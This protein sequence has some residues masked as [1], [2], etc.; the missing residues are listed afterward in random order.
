MS[1]SKDSSINVDA[2][3][4]GPRSE[5][6]VFFKEMM[7]FAVGEHVHWRANYHPEDPALVTPQQQYQPDFRHT[8]YRTEDILRQLSARLKAQ[9]V[10]FFSPRYLGH[11]NA[12]TLMVSNLAYTMTAMYNPNNCA[13]EVSPVTTQLELEVGQQL[14]QMFGYSPE[15]AWGHLTSGGTVANY[16]GL[17]VARNLKTFPMAIA[18]HQATADLVADL[19]EQDLLN[20]A[21]DAVLDLISASQ[22][23]GEF[24]AVRDLSARGVGVMPGQLGKLLVP[25][26]KHYSWQKAMDILGLGQ[27]N[28]VPLPLDENYRTDI[29]AL[30]QIVDEMMQAGTPILGVIAVVGTTEEGSVDPVDAVVALRERCQQQYGRSFYIHV[31]AAYAGYARSLFVG[32][33][34][35]LLAYDDLIAH[36]RQQDTIPEGVQWP[37]PEVYSAFAALSKVDSITVDPH[38]VGYIP[39]AA[40]AIVMR[41]RRIVD[42]ISYH[43]A[44]VF[45]GDRQGMALGS[46]IMEGSKAGATAAAVWAAHQLC[47]LSVNGYGEVIARGIVSAD[48]LAKAIESAPVFN[49]D[50]RQFQLNLMM[51]PDFHM[52]NF[53]LKEL[54]DDTLVGH[55]ALNQKVY[56]Y[57][58]YLSGRPYDKSFLTSSTTLSR[59]EHGE[60]PAHFAAQM[61]F[62]ASEWENTQEVYILRAAVMTHFLRDRARFEAYWQE[63]LA[64]FERIL[65]QIV[66]DEAR[67]VR[68]NAGQN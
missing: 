29:G 40:G 59:H 28:I 68:R 63:L 27:Q 13:A 4:L 24:E 47:P 42:L 11:M 54:G 10:P 6:R 36:Y 23:R 18:A 64:I 65:Q 8:L 66:E 1:H 56:H 34:H 21:P 19:S 38:K 31:D 51:Q 45:E 62:A 3:F 20:M 57:S 55:N 53:T 12:D 9:S 30:N 37:K 41:D 46:S 49:V 32:D 67:L 26:S 15:K 35:Q 61:G 14:A 5:N 44:Y 7:A 16:E 25:Q 48:W 58:S 22:Q 43:A 17:W 50:G 39:Y 33:D 2:L 60:A 52:V